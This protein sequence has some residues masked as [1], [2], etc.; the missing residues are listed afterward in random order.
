MNNTPR[1]ETITL[2]AGETLSVAIP[3][4]WLLVESCTAVSFQFA[5]DNDPLTTGVPYRT[6]PCRDG[7]EGLRFRDSIGAGCVIVVVIADE[8]PADNRYGADELTAIAASVA[9]IDID[10]D[11]IDVP[12][13]DVE[14]DIEAGNILLTA[15]QGDTSAMAVDLAALEV[16][17]TATNAAIAASDIAIS[18]GG[19]TQVLTIATVSTGAGANQACKGATF[20]TPDADIHFNLDAAA[21]ANDPLL[22]ADMPITMAI[23]NT[24]HLNFYNAGGGNETV[25]II[26]RN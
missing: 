21:D 20:W 8:V 9:A 22:P 12:L 23:H 4:K 17:V 11:N 16:L 19:G 2:A 6:Y 18:T 14:S 7:F 13:S 26:W 15:I 25:N 10:T 1:T 3:G 5:F 24:D